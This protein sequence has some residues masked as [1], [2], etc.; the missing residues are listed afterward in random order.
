[1]MAPLPPDHPPVKTPKI[2]V[3]LL[4]LGTPDGTGYWDMRRYLKEFLSDRRVIEVNP[5]FWQILLN[6][7]ILT[8]RPFSSGEAYKSI[9]DDERNESPLRTISREQAKKLGARFEQIY[10]GE[11]VVDWGLRY[12]NPT[13]A[14]R[15]EALFDQG[16][17][18]IL[19]FP[20][21]PQYA[22]A[23]TATANDQAFRAL[24][25][26][27][28][29]P[30]IRTVPPYHDHPTYIA[31][32]ARSVERHLAGLDWQ[33][34]VLVTSFHGLPKRYL[35]AGDPYHCQCQKTAR[36]L[37]ERLGWPEEKLQIA[38]QS[39]FGNEEWLRPYTVEHVAELARS[40]VK[41]L[42][43]IAPGFAADCV[44][45]LEE[46]QEEIRGAFEEAG[47]E[48]FTYIPCLNASDDH[49]GLLG[50]IVERELKGWIEPASARVASAA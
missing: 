10:G 18:R 33:P 16:C 20:L 29:Q 50:E 17:Q 28:W 2:G 5:V 6:T 46:I 3:L 24:M 41:D 27:R 12:G 30:A 36:L 26:M 38:F 45:T 25:K 9:W 21:Y 8:K 35:L 14:S 34:E 32:L 7:V 49:I 19:L 48:R 1:M 23:T 22:A 11:V 40:G 42:A 43:I 13:T 39:L 47:G 37:R 15:L 44:E 31:A 4:N